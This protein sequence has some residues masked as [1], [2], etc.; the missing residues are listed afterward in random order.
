MK[1]NLF[2]VVAHSSLDINFA[3]KRTIFCEKE[4]C[5]EKS[6]FTQNSLNM[7]SGIRKCSIPAKLDIN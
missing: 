5:F 7:N 2:F 3:L 6:V 4:Y 1:N